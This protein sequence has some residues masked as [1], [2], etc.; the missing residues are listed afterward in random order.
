M[1]KLSYNIY[2]AL[3]PMVSGII[4]LTVYFK[5]GGKGNLLFGG[6]NLIAGLISLIAFYLY[7]RKFSKK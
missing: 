7:K 5:A 4:F 6:I 3:L 1:K 2:Y